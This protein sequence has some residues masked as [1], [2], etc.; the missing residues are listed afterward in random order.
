MDEDGGKFAKLTKTDAGLTK[1]DGSAKLTEMSGNGCKS[2]KMGEGGGRI[3]GNGR[4]R[5]QN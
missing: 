3:D 4:R 1:M 2:T 5:E